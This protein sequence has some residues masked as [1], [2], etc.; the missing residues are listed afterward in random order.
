MTTYPR[1]KFGLGLLILATLS[2]EAKAATLVSTACTSAPGASTCALWAKP[3]TVTLPGAQAPIAIWGYTDSAAATATASGPVLIVNQGDVVTVTLTN[4]LAEATAILFQGQDMAPDLSGVAP[5]AAKSYT[6]TA[7][8]P[9]TFL[10]EAGLLPNAQHQAAMG[11]HG[12]LI[13]RPTAAAGQAYASPATAFVDEDVLVL[14]EIDPL[15]NA[16]PNPATFD[17]RDFSPRY[18]LINGKPYNGSNI[19]TTD[20]IA[21]AAGNAVLLRYVNAGIQQHSMTVL[22]M[23]QTLVGKDGSPLAFS[24]KR[25]A[26]TIAPGETLDAIVTVPAGTANG[27]RFA[28]YDGSMMLH[29]AGSSTLGGMLTFLVAGAIG[30]PGP[31][32]VGPDAIGVGVTPQATNGTSSV[33]LTATLSDTA[34]GNSNVIAAEYFVDTAGA[35]GSGTPM[36][37]AFGTP[38]VAVSAT[39]GAG[40]VAALAHGNHTLYVHGQDANG[41]WGSL[42]LAVLNVD[43]VGPVSS[44]LTLTPNPSNGSVAVALHATGNDSTTGGSNVSAAE[45]FI[46]TPGANGTGTAMTVNAVSPVASLDA[47][48]S[49]PAAGGVV[50][51]HAQDALGNWGAFT[52]ITLVVTTAGPTTSNVIATRNPNNGTYPL[53]TSNPVLR[54][55]ATLTG[56]GATPTGAEGFIDTVGSNGTGFQ[57]IPVD[58]AWGPA[59]SPPEVAYA[60]IP[61]TTINT[62]SS[63]NHT[64]YVHGKDAA[65]NWGPTVTATL[66]IDRTAPTFTGITLAP[67]PTF[68]ATSVTMTVNGASDPLVAGLAAGVAGGEYWIGTTVPA[69]GGGTAFTGL[70]AAIQVG[71]LATGTYTIGARVRD[72]AGNWST[73][74]GGTRTA[75]LQVVPDAIFSNGFETGNRPWGWSSASTNSTSRLN[76]FTGS[77]V[78]DGTRSLQAQGNNTNYVQYSFG[79]AANPASTTFDARF[80]FNPNGNTGSNQDILVARTTGG[81]TVFRV[82]YRSSAGQPQVQIQIGTSTANASW[83]NIN[84]AASNSIEVV[85]Q[86]VNSSGP[87]PGTLRLVVNGTAVQTLTTTTNTSSVGSVRLGSV[88]SGGNN[89][90]EYFDAFVAKRSPTPLIGP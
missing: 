90:L 18:F 55:T 25:A 85:W 19:P 60:D 50:S 69:P 42:N 56:A 88:T 9:G 78:L 22:G 26:E 52:T 46:G 58:G 24:G 36:T 30:A 8:N 51:V 63:G 66:L 12:A 75:T 23:R 39:L 34:K 87:N 76:V 49:P 32:T 10:Y 35:N 70:T 84:G 74:T 7:T 77:G 6:F 27:T 47:T 80:H 21:T 81:N 54:V 5:A 53:N 14:S 45:Y 31:D 37:G 41:N 72:A 62:L 11:L 86:A 2:G 71:S 28:V 67:N 61:L 1:Q 44:G 79:D 16:T 33:A 40:T 3:G 59:G 57:F 68:G 65:G 48:I 38:T 83:S 43:K 64:I 4:Q 82:R 89:T 20:P 17:L 15:L 13:V 73:G 29:N